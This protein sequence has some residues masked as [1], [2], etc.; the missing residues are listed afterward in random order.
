MRSM[1]AEARRQDG[2]QAAGCGRNPVRAALRA[3]AESATDL[4]TKAET[5][6]LMEVVC[7]RG[8]LWL[9]YQR[10]VENKGAAGVDGIG[11]TEFKDHL[12]RHW[13]TIRARLLAGTYIPQA[14]RRVDIPK[15]QGGVRTLGIPTLTDRLIQQALHQVLSP[16]FEAEFSE[17]SYGFRPGRNAHQ[18]VKAAQRYV[19]EGR[20]VVV[21][22]DLEKFFDRVNHDILMEKVSKKV[23]DG[24]VLKLIRRYL[25]AGM[26]TDGV[27]SPRTEGTPQGG[28]LSPLLSNILLTELDRELERRGHAFCRY[29]DDCNIY[30]RSQV[31]GERVLASITRF[32]TERLRLTVNA[33]KSAVAAPWE[34]KFLGYSLTWHKA[35]KLRIAPTSLKRLEDKVREVLKGA[36]GRSLSRTIAELNPVLRGWAA[37]FK[38][39]ETKGALEEIDGWLRRKLRCILW[40]QWKRPYTRAK[41]L[42]K[43]GLTE[44]RA[45]RSAFNQR[46]PWWNSGARHMNAAFRKSFFD[47]MGLVSLLDTTRRLQCLS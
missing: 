36:R 41:N 32:L 17:S 7:E 28:P 40:R 6:G 25:E 4:R 31:A 13:P 19:A 14:V 29:A 11:V 8:N 33:T 34:R 15:P 44:E 18:A 35:P 10:V 2:A 30:V 39:T 47:R 26:M 20:R 1:K 46:G 24:R 22:M 3:E 16:I 12:K 45:F 9:A 23:G 42:I 21:D 27:V 5:S 37:Y 38:L 43:A